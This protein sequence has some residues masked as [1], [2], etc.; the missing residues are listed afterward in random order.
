MANIHDGDN[1]DKC[2]SLGDT[3]TLNSTASPKE[4]SHDEAAEA[5]KPL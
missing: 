1:E 5:E 4:G 3:R 2:G